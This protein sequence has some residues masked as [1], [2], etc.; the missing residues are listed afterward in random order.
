MT[1]WPFDPQDNRRAA[2][3][4]K[5]ASKSSI[6]RADKN[7]GINTSMKLFDIPSGVRGEARFQ[8]MGTRS[9]KMASKTE[10]MITTSPNIAPLFFLS[11]RHDAC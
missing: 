4:G 1:T 3:A 7:G 9:A 11:L 6:V 10:S 5:V 2:F 8:A